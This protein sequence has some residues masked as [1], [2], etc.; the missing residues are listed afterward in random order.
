MDL[1]KIQCK[2]LCRNS[3]F[4]IS[5]EDH[6]QDVGGDRAFMAPELLNKEEHNEKVDVWSVGIIASILL[7]GKHPFNISY[8]SSDFLEQ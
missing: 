3:L 4:P 8:E 2:L 5:E 7:T 6:I 1:S